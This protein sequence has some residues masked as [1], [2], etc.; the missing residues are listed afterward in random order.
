ME[1]ELV[2]VDNQGMISENMASSSLEK[3]D[4]KFV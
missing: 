2:E 3:Q 4:I 1:W